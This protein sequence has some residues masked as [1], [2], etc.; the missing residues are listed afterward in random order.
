M[1]V[2]RMGDEISNI[3]LNFESGREVSEFAENHMDKYLCTMDINLST[4]EQLLFD[5]VETDDDENIVSNEINDE[6]F[7]FLHQA[8]LEP[9]N[10]N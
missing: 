10:R 3:L 4:I 9:E 5:S 2:R 6:R 1:G 7:A 8:C